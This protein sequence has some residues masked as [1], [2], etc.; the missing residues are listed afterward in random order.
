MPTAVAPI[1]IAFSTSVP[2]AKLP[3]MMTGTRPFTTLTTSGRISIA[4][5]VIGKVDREA[6]LRRVA[7]VLRA[8]VELVDIFVVAARVELEDLEGAGRL[9]CSVLR[10]RLGRGAL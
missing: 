6:E 5:R 10:T 9:L 7:A 4:P 8:L 1:A 3:S 2:R